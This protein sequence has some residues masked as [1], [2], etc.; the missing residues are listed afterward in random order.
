[1]TIRCDLLAVGTE[2]LLGQIVDS[3]SAWLGERLAAAGIGSHLHVQVGDNVGRIER[4]LRNLLADADAVI[5][6][7][8][9]GPTHDDLTREAIAA[10]MGDVDLVLDDDVAAVITEMFAVRGREMAQNNLR[11]ALVPEG[12]SVIPQTTGTAP[13]LICPVDVDGVTKTVYAMPGVP[14]EM[15]EMFARAVLPD[16]LGRDADVGTIVSQVIKVWG[17]SESGLNARLEDVIEELDARSDVTLAFL[18]RG[19]NGLEIR[20]TARAATA[21]AAAESVAPIEAEIRRR[22]GVRIFGTNGDSME[23]AVIDL[24]RARGETIGLAESLTAGLVASRLAEVPGCGDVLRGG[25][26]SYATDVKFNVLGVQP[27]P[28]VTP[29]AAL[30]MAVGAR[31]LL[32]ADWG[33]GLSGVAGP[34]RQ[35]GV[36]VGTVHIAVAGPAGERTH[37]L[38]LG[39]RTDRETV[40]QMAVIN[41]LDLL[42]KQLLA[43]D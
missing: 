6:C 7:G 40:R 13:G 2:L 19:W 43:V 28:V 29:E 20:L 23:S 24:L 37:L 34:D 1:M 42:R 11:Q 26:V 3:N 16:L 8:G 27:G 36:P 33:L 35:E 31:R 14:S 38:R 17:E 15:R 10:V 9:L 18:A 21:A 30:E 25:V 5:V 4:Q 22:L 32:D 41:A 12:A 39:E